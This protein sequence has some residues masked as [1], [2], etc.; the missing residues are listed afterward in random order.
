MPARGL[1]RQRWVVKARELELEASHNFLRPNLDFVG[2]YGMRGFGRNLLDTNRSPGDSF[3][4]VYRSLVNGDYPE[5]QVGLEFSMPIGFRDAHAGV[6]NAELGVTQARAILRE[7]ELQVLNNLTGAVDQVGRAF[8][9]LQTSINRAIA[10]K[11][12]LKSLRAAYE[13]DKAELF[14]VLDAHRRYAEALSGYYQARVEYALAIRN[15]YFEKGSLL[16]YCDI[17]L[18][19]GS[20]PIKA[21]SDAAQRERLRGRSRRIDF[22]LRRPPIVSQGPSQP[23]VENYPTTGADSRPTLPRRRLQATRTSNRPLLLVF[24]RWKCLPRHRSLRHLAGRRGRTSIDRPPSPTRPQVPR[25]QLHP[26]CNRI[27]GTV[28]DRRGQILTC[29][30]QAATAIPG[31]EQQARLPDGSFAAKPAVQAEQPV[32][33]AAPLSRFKI[34]EDD[35][36]DLRLPRP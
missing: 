10:A 16:E 15:V 30:W 28:P 18:A 19:E 3:D 21:Y 29:S 9:V 12:Q 17:A 36:A 5:W 6:R 22:T 20:W 27:A 31:N 35:P 2:R 24:T 11:D 7:Q 4:S 1:R 8:L 13:A 33:V 25:R 26:A 32:Q 14:V 34:Q 23:A